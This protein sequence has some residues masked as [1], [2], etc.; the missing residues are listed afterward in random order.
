MHCRHPIAPSADLAAVASAGLAFAE[1]ASAGLVAAFAEPASAGLAVA[2]VACPVARAYLAHKF[3]ALRGLDAPCADCF[4]TSA[5]LVVAVADASYTRSVYPAPAVSA[6]PAR[7]FAEHAT[8][9]YRLALRGW[10]NCHT[11]WRFKMDYVK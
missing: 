3:H 10:Q 9:D 6:S 8:L 2:W 7:P 1:P 4:D 5:Q 11:K